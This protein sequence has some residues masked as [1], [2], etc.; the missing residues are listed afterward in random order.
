M[1]DLTRF[2]L[3][4]MT[5]CGAAMRRMGQGAS[6]ME[7]VAARIVRHLYDEMV[8]PDTGLRSLRL[9][10]LFK[11]HSYGDLDIG[12][13]QFVTNVLGHEPPV[14]ETNCLTLLATSGA[15][16]EWNSRIYSR[17]HKA[18]PLASEDMVRAF[19][20]ISNLVS[21]LGLE[22][23]DVVDPSPN[24]LVDMEQRAFNVFFEPN[25]LGSDFIVAQEEFV[26]PEGIQSCLGFGGVLPGGDL[27][28]VIMFSG[29]PLTG[30]V[31]S[32]FQ[33]ISLSVKLALMPFEDRVFDDAAIPVQP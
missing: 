31:A 29:V 30:E 19:P 32:M 15:R 6:S 2:T 8:E 26:I 33:T 12:L 22:L 10:R 23:A 7:Q 28:T 16:P 27:F 18:I 25:A 14:P 17:G 21:Q 3:A 11:T 13:R 9:V 20:M 4:D 5:R 24:V 1:Y